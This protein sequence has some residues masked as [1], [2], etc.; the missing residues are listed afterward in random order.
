MKSVKSILDMDLI[1]VDW[2]NIINININNFVNQ[3]E[4]KENSE[5]LSFLFI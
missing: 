4:S 1:Q 2:K 3:S 5:E